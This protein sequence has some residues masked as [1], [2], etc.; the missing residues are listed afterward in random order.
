MY[1]CH[2]RFYLTGV[3][4]S[5]RKLIEEAAPLNSFTHT[6]WSSDVPEAEKTA[7]A[8]VLFADLR[9]ADADETLRTIAGCR[10]KEAELILIV[11]REQIAS[12]PEELSAAED[13]WIMPMSDKEL[14]FRFRKWQRDYKRKVDLWESEHFMD[15]CINSSPNL[16]WFKD[17]EGVHEIVNDS[18][19]KVVNKK[20][21][22]VEGR[23]H[24]YIWDVE[25]DDPACIESEQE[26]MRRKETCVAQEYIQT[27]DG[28]RTLTTYKS[29][30]YDWDGS[31]MGTVGV[32]V[33]VTKEQAYEQ[34]IIEKNK[35]LE[36]LFL[37]W[38][39]V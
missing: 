10:K 19:C 7:Q 27:G 14:G 35:T 33:D 5:I 18:F 23:R 39:A 17:K 25:Q 8:D 22:Q 28:E 34:K 9:K 3:Q 31:V 6:F 26:V 13:I 37:P 16:I 4:D 15:I 36:M 38:T 29:P 32:A 20:K 2:I 12:L 1:H 24:A 11:D 21:E 30:L